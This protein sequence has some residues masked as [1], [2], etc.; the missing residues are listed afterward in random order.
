MDEK[1]MKALNWSPELIEAVNRVAKQVHAGAV[2]QEYTTKGLEP[3]PSVESDSL[4]LSNT[5]PSASN[6]V[7]FAKTS[8]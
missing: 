5:E 8:E 3:H 4:T 2:G 6:T 1:I 7:V